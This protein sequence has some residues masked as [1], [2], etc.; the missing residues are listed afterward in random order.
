MKK[1]EIKA[2]MQP[3]GDQPKAIEALVRGIKEDKKKTGAFRGDRN[4]EDFYH[5]ECDCPNAKAGL[6]FGA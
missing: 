5:G 4:G 1:F 6:D 3:K 2:G